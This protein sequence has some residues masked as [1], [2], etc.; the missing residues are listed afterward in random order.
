MRG[1]TAAVRRRA[2]PRRSVAGRGDATAP[3]SALSPVAHVEPPHQ[4]DR[5]WTP[6]A[7]T[8]SPSSSPHR[9][10][11]RRQALAQAGTGLAAGALAAAG[12][13]TP[14]TP[15]TPPR[16]D[17]ATGEK[18]RV[19]LRP[20]VPVRQHRPQ[21][22]RRRARYTLT[23][24]QGLGQTIYF[25]DRPER[26]RRRHPDRPVPGGAR[27]PARQPAQRRPGGRGGA[28]RDRASRW[29]S[30]ST[31]PTTRPPTPPPTRWRCWRSGS[32]RWGW[33]FRAAD[34]PGAAAPEFGA[35]HLFMTTA[36]T[37]RTATTVN[38]NQYVGLLPGGP[39][40]QCWSWTPGPAR[41]PIATADT[42]R[43]TMTP[44]ATGITTTPAL[45]PVGAATQ[46]RARQPR[47]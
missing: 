11:S 40:G 33:A 8:R 42:P 41:P 34:G 15:R 32:G 23:L 20:V 25:S 39:A 13:A 44:S 7:S 26:D 1:S 17:R 14:P 36:P 30:C 18:I 21:G 16:A 22:G 29:W 10:L 46:S 9:R 5:P 47:R 27:L 31:R 19:P 35:A 43:T 3:S 4:G 37:S 38:T 45:L 28:G 6:P 24:E 2:C 12:L